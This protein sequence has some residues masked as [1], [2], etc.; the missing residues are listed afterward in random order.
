MQYLL[1]NKGKINIY[2]LKAFKTLRYAEIAEL[3]L[4]CGFIK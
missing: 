2:K 4:S 1:P 3:Q